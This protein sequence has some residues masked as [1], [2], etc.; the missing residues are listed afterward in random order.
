M[1]GRHNRLC[2]LVLETFFYWFLQ[3]CFR[4][5]FIANL[6]SISNLWDYCSL[7]R[8]GAG[9]AHTP[10]C[11]HL[12]LCVDAI[13][14][15]IW[16]LR[17]WCTSR[18]SIEQRLKY[19]VAT[20]C[21]RYPFL[22]CVLLFSSLLFIFFLLR[23]EVWKSSEHQISP[24]RVTTEWHQCCWSLWALLSR[25]WWGSAPTTPSPVT[26][27]VHLHPA[28]MLLHPADYSNPCIAHQWTTGL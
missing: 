20:W 7:H 26:P 3:K 28:N 16:S 6:K 13:T 25:P 14:S 2:F 9:C 18:N 5:Y 8:S 1:V 10:V 15:Y 4:C 24:C 19:Q 27:F 17:T 22:T 21:P 12:A 23:S 11:V